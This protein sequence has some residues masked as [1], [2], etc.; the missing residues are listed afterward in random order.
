MTKAKTAA[1]KAAATAEAGFA[2]GAEALKTGFD[3]A[4]KNYD[5]VLGY[6]I[7]QNGVQGAHASGML[8]LDGGYVA[9]CIP[10]HLID[11]V[12]ELRNLKNIA[13]L[14]ERKAKHRELVARIQARV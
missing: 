14:D 1:D 6:G 11:A 4:I 13:D 5:L 3:K 9:P 7:D 10:D 12:S 2:S 8:L